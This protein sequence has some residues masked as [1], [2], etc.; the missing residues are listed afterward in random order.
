[1]GHHPFILKVR[2]TKETIETLR[3]GLSSSHN[4]ASQSLQQ[5]ADE[6]LALLRRTSQS[7]GVTFQAKR[8]LSEL[9]ATSE[10]DVTAVY[11]ALEKTVGAP[12]IECVRFYARSLDRF[13][14]D[15]DIIRIVRSGLEEFARNP[16]F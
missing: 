6:L 15:R 5:Q 1:M 11:A 9:L 3:N 4:D 2:A 16:M 10:P 12:D 13:Q 8:E 14:Q 7:L